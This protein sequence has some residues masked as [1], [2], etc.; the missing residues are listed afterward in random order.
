MAREN[1]GDTSPFSFPEWRW[2]RGAR[3]TTWRTR[4]TRLA[5]ALAQFLRSRTGDSISQFSLPN[6]DWCCKIKFVRRSYMPEDLFHKLQLLE[7]D[8]Q[9]QPPV[10]QQADLR[11]INQIRS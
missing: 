9:V 10:A 3:P 11:E 4:A 2:R 1:K 5:T 7:E 8:Y 6:Q